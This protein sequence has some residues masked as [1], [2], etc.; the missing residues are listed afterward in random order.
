MLSYLEHALYLHFLVDDLPLEG[1]SFLT[2]QNTK[3]AFFTDFNMVISQ[4][5]YW[6]T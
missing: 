3:I 5:D 2:G 6:T 1:F 4:L